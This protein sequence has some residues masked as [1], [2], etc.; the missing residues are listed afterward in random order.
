VV[1]IILLGL[2]L[3]K[4]FIDFKLI[5]SIPNKLLKPVKLDV[6]GGTY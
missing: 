5:R 3:P 2:D 1:K 6:E 4:L